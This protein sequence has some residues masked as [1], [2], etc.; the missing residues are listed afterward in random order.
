MAFRLAFLNSQGDVDMEVFDSTRTR[1]GRSDSSQ[2][3]EQVSINAVAGQFYYV[4]VYGFNGATNPNYTFT[5]DQPEGVSGGAPDQFEDNDTFATARSLAA[6]DQSYTNLNINTSGDD[7][8]YKITPTASGT[9]TVNLAFVHTQGDID[10]EILNASQARLGI[11]DS[12]SNSEQVSLQVTAGQTYYIWAYGYHG[13]TNS[14]YSMAIDVPTSGV[15]PPDAFEENDTVATARSLA[16]LDQA[17]ANLNI[18]KTGDDDFYKIVPAASGMLNLNLAFQN[19]QGN[20]DMQILNS[21][22]VQLGLSASTANSEQL[23]VPVTAGQT[24]Y[25]RVYGFQGA[26][27]ANYTMTVDVPSASG[28]TPDTLEENDTIATV[29]SLSAVSQTFQNLSIDATGDDDYY[30]IVP[31]TTGIYSFSLAFVH[32]SGDIDMDVLN[33]TGT[34]LGRSESTGNSEQLNVNLT[35]GQTYYI[36]ASAIKAP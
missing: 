27:N 6:V 4:R 35:A 3:S 13:A 9:M 18:D 28:I 26:V 36:R 25:V 7:D 15:I 19:A 23:S 21:A 14:N 33:S 34:R 11:S 17:Y 32:A 2:N 22:Q 24:Y 1:I 8:Y 20:V 5:V 16:A 30:R 10:L 31:T 29:R 12:T